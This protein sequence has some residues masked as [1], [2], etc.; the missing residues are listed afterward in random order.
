MLVTFLVWAITDGH[1][2]S[3][4]SAITQ[5]VAVTEVVLIWTI[6][7][8]TLIRFGLLSMVAAFFFFNLL[9]RWPLVLDTSV[10]FASTSLVGLLLLA[11]IAALAAWISVGRSPGRMIGH[12]ISGSG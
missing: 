7:L 2:T 8:G 10:W 9:Q 11:A 3:T 4:G 5:I 12:Q 1:W 6:L